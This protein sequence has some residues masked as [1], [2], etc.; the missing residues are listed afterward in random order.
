[1]Y[2]V[3]FVHKESECSSSPDDI[4][5]GEPSLLIILP[6]ASVEDGAGNVAAKAVASQRNELP[7]WKTPWRL[8]PFSKSQPQL[9]RPLATSSLAS[10]AKES[11]GMSLI[12]R[13][14]NYHCSL[15]LRNLN[16]QAS[17]L[18]Y[19]A[20]V[21]VAHHR[22]SYRLE[23]ESLLLSYRHHAPAREFLPLT[24]NSKLA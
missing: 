18:G 13:R 22:C 24:M 4:L 14:R 16:L 23:Q 15:M 10:V 2:A 12:T 1:L 8:R 19:G 7:T 11:G 5:G 3:C 6:H 17:L 21:S 20:D 9:S